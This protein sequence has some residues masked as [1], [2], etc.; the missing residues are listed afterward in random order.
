MNHKETLEEFLEQYNRFYGE[1]DDRELQCFISFAEGKMTAKECEDVIQQY[2]SDKYD[3]ML[4][5]N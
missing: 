2:Y 5:C 4:E 3:N 1:H